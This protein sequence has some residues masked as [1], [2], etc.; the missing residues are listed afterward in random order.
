MI[1]MISHI[2]SGHYF[3]H[4]VTRIVVVGFGFGGFSFCKKMRRR[5]WRKGMQDVDILVISDRRY[6]TFTP[7]L[8][9]LAVSRLSVESASAD[10]ESLGKVLGFR[11]M[12]GRVDGIDMRARKVSVKGRE[13]GYD[14]MVLSTGSS[15]NLH[16]ISISGENVI[17]LRNVEDASVVAEKLLRSKTIW[18]NPDKSHYQITVIGGGQTG[19]EAASFLAERLME[20]GRTTSK[21]SP[22]IILLEASGRILSREPDEVSEISQ[23][24]LRSKGVEYRTNINVKNIDGSRI[25][26]GSGEI[27]HSGTIIWAAG[28]RPNTWMFGAQGILQTEGGRIV[29]NAR[30][31]IPGIKNAYVI[32][33]IASPIV[34]DGK[35]LA[36]N[37]SVAVQEGKFLARHIANSILQGKHNEVEVFRYRNFGHVIPLGQDSLFIGPKNRV[38]AGPLGRGI[39]WFIH[40]IELF[41][42]QNRVRFLLESILH[43][44]K[45]V[46]SGKDR[47][48]GRA[49]ACHGCQ[50]S[51][52]T[53]ERQTL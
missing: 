52:Q 34:G 27:L 2:G 31:E 47:S 1:N 49:S 5:S 39:A 36:E 45:T 41:T 29:V 18:E 30:L 12:L 3:T 11:F 19:V 48:P 24:I 40:F 4:P 10:I 37:A 38:L 14:I 26:L 32:G 42:N 6:I 33:D 28:I 44:A 53:M 50:E 15:D 25:L 13:I 43:R 17:S 7:L 8:P 22:G 23:R 9:E 21:D 20:I 46:R 16:G 51:S 35:I